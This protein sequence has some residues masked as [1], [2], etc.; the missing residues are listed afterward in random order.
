M[1]SGRVPRQAAIV[2]IWLLVVACDLAVPSTTRVPEA[3]PS[4]TSTP[5]SSPS[6]KSAS[7]EVP[8]EQNE[9]QGLDG[10]SN[11]IA[12]SLGTT[13]LTCEGDGDNVR[14]DSDIYAVGVDGTNQRRLTNG[15]GSKGWSSWSPDGRRIAYRLTPNGCDFNR[16][17]LAIVTV[18]DLNV[19]VIVDEAWSPAWSPNGD[20]IAYYA[21]SQRY[22]L[23]LVRPDGSDD[24][25]ILA[26]DAEY[27]GW[28]PDG[29]RLAFMSLGFPGGSSSADYDV[30]VIDADG[31]NLQQ[32]TT[33][34]GEDGWPAWS[35]DGSRI[36]YVHMPTEEK[37]EIHLMTADG[38]GDVLITNP[39]EELEA[40]APKWSPNDI[41]LAYQA[42][43]P[44]EPATG[45]VF[46][47]HPDGTG[48]LKLLSDGSEPAWMP[49]P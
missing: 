7:T 19:D 41:Y 4:T 49:L 34:P 24:H 33:T 27:P 47:I 13:R 11:T 25:Q 14:F 22:G 38:R 3:M 20:W 16:S 29:K 31:Q 2:L 39:I 17:N 9:S 46:V 37:S 32:L 15:P 6:A 1:P 21:A 35:H 12:V 5:E 36:A 44:R 48:R 40:W 10:S 42:Y 8:V 43:G 45:G 23:N 26:G 18:A 28:S 30:Y